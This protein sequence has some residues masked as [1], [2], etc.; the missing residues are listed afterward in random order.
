[1]RF[2]VAWAKTA[3]ENVTLK[4]ATITLAVVVVAEL[5]MIAGLAVKDP[6]IIERA[7]FSRVLAGKHATATAEEIK[8]FLTEAITIRFDSGVQLKE[9]YLAI[10]ETLSRERELAALAQRQMTQRVFVT[11]I[12]MDPKKIIVTAD[13]LISVGKI[14]SVLPLVIQVTVLETDRSEVNPYGLIISSIA[15][16]QAR[17]EKN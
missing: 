4:V 3:A 11:K 12:D 16:A 8:S 1:M 5:T 7:C 17:E 10:A 9:G 13:R 14:K 15:E 2:S 6:L